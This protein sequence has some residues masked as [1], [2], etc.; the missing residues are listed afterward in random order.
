MTPRP[1]KIIC[2]PHKELLRVGYKSNNKQYVV[3]NLYNDKIFS[4]FGISLS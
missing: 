3:N 4:S 2:G 1:E